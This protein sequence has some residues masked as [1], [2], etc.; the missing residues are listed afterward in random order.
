MKSERGNAICLRA[1]TQTMQIKINTTKN[2]NLTS[3]VSSSPVSSIIVGASIKRK[4]TI[5]VQILKSFVPEGSPRAYR[6]SR[7][8]LYLA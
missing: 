2:R 6:A 4:Y 1:K 3:P 8:A 5:Y 7:S